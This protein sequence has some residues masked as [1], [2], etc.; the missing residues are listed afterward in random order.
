MPPAQQVLYSSNHKALP[1]RKIYGSIRHLLGRRIFPG[2]KIGEGLLCL[3]FQ[4]TFPLILGGLYYIGGIFHEEKSFTLQMFVVLQGYAVTAKSLF[5]IP[6]WWFFFIRLKHYSLGV[7]ILLHVFTSFLYA[8]LV[9]GVVYLGK[10]FL[11]NQGYEKPTVL[12]DFYFILISYFSHF[13]MFHAYNFWLHSKKQLKTEHA[14]KEIAYQNEIKALRAQIEPHF[15]FNTLN[16]ISASVPPELERTRVLIAQLA[17]TFRYALQVSECNWV[18]LEEEIQFIKTWLALEKHRLDERLTVQY[19]ID[20]DILHAVIPAMI[21][22][23]LVENAIK[24]GICAKIEGGII[25]IE[26]KRRNNLVCIRIC[27]TG[28]GFEGDL[29]EMFSRGIGLKNIFERLQRLY[30]ESL[31]VQR[32]QQGLQFSFC[33]PINEGGYEES[34]YN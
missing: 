13:F 3:L 27:D 30:N 5:L 10:E 9:V 33:I 6:F 14:L 29:Q 21:I 24:H 4:F 7:K 34:A 2:F 20:E 17:D 28:G 22:Q 18:R 12:L 15:L 32:L 16:S 26:C 31:H 23:P 25:T 1:S 11:F 19:A 8:G